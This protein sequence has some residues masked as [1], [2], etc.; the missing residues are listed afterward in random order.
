[1]IKTF[2]YEHKD[3]LHNVIQQNNVLSASAIKKI[4]AFANPNQEDLFYIESVL[5][6][7]GWN[8]NDDVFDKIESWNARNTPVDKQFNYQHNEHDIIGHITSSKIISEDGK[9]ISDDTSIEN[10]P[11]KYDILVGSVLYRHWADAKLQ[12]RMNQLIAEIQ[13]GKWFV[14]M[15]CFFS[16]FDYALIDPTGSHQSLARNDQTSFLTKHLRCYGGKGEYQGYKVGRLL[17]NFTFSGKGLVSDPANKRSV[18]FNFSDTSDIE[19]DF[20]VAASKEKIMSEK[21]VQELEMKLA[22]AEK[23]AKDVADKAVANQ[24][25]EF[26]ASVAKLQSQLESAQSDLKKASDKITVLE[27]VQANKLSEIETLTKEVTDVKA[28]LA[29]KSEQ[30]NK[31]EAEKTTAAR[32]ELFSDREVDSAKARNL[33]ELGKTMTDETFQILV[34]SFAKKED[35]KEEMKDDKKK[36]KKE[37]K[38]DAGKDEILEE[39]EVIGAAL[40]VSDE[41]EDTDKIRTAA[42]SWMKSLYT[43][44]K[45]EN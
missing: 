18:I 20:K 21:T 36:D 7:I 23:A 25:A 5:A 44:N 45:K 14:S 32:L 15:E 43:K 16:G 28:E 40:S 29:E 34:D 11:D 4:L 41:S 6:S 24:I 26:E 22:A 10:L 1:M 35:K 27:E 39:L 37:D 2:N 13:E 33:V 31:V 38:A 8:D 3:G 12:D 9:I 17:K 42:S 19:T 30:L